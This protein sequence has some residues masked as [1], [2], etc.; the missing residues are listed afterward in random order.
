MALVKSSRRHRNAFIDLWQYFSHRTIC[1]RSK[2]QARLLLFLHSRP[3][4]NDCRTP[5]N[6]NVRVDRSVVRGFQNN[7]SPIIPGSQRRHLGRVIFLA[8]L[9]TSSEEAVILRIH[10]HKPSGVERRVVI[11]ELKLV[12]LVIIRLVRFPS[13]SMKNPPRRVILETL[14][15]LFCGELHEQAPDFRVLRMK[16]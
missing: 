16:D 15:Y 6:S 12:S 2:A 11:V 7:R 13:D 10:L 3:G 1:I 14:L 9:T 4:R 5:R 8:G